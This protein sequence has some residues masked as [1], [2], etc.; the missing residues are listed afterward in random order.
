M[1]KLLVFTVAL[2]AVFLISSSRAEA[3]FEI[4][5]RYWFST[6][7][8]DIKVT[9]GGLIGTDI[10]LTKDLGVDDEES[11]PEVRVR[12]GLG[13]HH[14]R[15]SY[16]SL[17]WD[18]TKSIAEVA[19]IDFGGTNFAQTT[20][21]KTSLDIEY[22]RLAYEYDLFDLMRNR[23]TLIAELKYLDVD[24]ELDAPAVA[25]NE[26]ESISIPLP[27]VGIG[28]QAGLPALL[29]VSAEVTGIGL[30]SDAYFVD[31]EAMINFHPAPLFVVSG[32][33]R[34]INLH[35]DDNDDELDFILDGPFL[36]VKLG[37]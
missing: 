30:G 34:Y 18:G 3:V 2:F 5:G 26:S 16:T 4:E 11:F 12:V 32:G 35:V 37:F 13:S 23:V 15:Y 36:M 24:A 8:S 7:D 6:L 17:S 25:L 22:H 10:D 33:Y 1:K 29:D 19:G 9:D 27:T 21:V 31:A 20:F 28:V 14:L